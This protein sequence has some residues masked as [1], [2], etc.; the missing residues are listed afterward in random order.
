MPTTI[1]MIN[2][3]V[4]SRPLLTS[5]VKIS[6]TPLRLGSRPDSGIGVV[7]E[8]VAPVSSWNS[9]TSQAMMPPTAMK[10]SMIVAIT[11]LM[12]RL[13]LSTPANPA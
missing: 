9:R 13:T 1:A 6:N 8:L 12:P 5:R 7:P 4:S 3:L 2:T 11:S 10:L